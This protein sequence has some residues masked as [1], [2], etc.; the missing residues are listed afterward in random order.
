[1]S[2]P[3]LVLA[4]IT[5]ISAIP[6]LYFSAVEMRSGDPKTRQV[7]QYT[8]A[9]S[10]ALFVLA[11]VPLFG[12]NDGWLLAIA[13]AMLI[14][15]GIDGVI[16]LRGRLSGAGGPLMN[17]VGPFATAVASAAALWWFLAVG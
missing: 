2:A 1:M 10:F 15:Q 11:L 9:R 12:R 4:V 6:S 7:A 8:T 3:Y 14:V 5:L 17:I 13:T 16:A